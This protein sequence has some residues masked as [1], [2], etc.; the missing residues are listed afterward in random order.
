MGIHG[1]LNK[2]VVIERAW[3]KLILFFDHN[4]LIDS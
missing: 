2:A 1:N 4:V 3:S